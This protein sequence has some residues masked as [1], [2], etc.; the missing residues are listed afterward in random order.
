MFSPRRPRRRLRHKTRFDQSEMKRTKPLILSGIFF[1]CLLA[2][3][4]SPN[5]KGDGTVKISVSGS[6]GLAFTGSCS[7][8]S[9]SGRSFTQE[10][11]GV[12]PAKFT[13]TIGSRLDYSIQ[14]SGQGN[15]V[16]RVVSPFGESVAGTATGTGIG[17][18]GVRGKIR[19]W[20]ESTEPF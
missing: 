17:S 7:G 15:L 20:S 19:S 16:V 11:N 12:V 4:A 14:K 9:W 6:D 8:R 2:G 10:F 18:R 13:F 5:T 3:C 1:V